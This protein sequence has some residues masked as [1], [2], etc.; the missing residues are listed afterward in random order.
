VLSPALFALHPVQAEA[1]TYASGRSA[2]L[3]GAL[4]LASVAAWLVGRERNEAGLAA[5]LSPALFA[6][7]LATK[8]SVVA[9]PIAL[10]VLLAVD[11]RRPFRAADALRATA[12]HWGVLGAAAVA[13]AASPV[14]R[15]MLAAS[16]ALRPPGE[17]SLTHLDALAWLAA[18][19]VRLDR[20]SADP[21]LAPV[22]RVGPGSVI[23]A[24]ALI[25]AVVLGIAWARRRPAIAFGIL[26]FLAWLPLAGFLLPRAD[27]ANERQL[28]LSLAGPAWLAGLVLAPWAT[29]GGA[30]R[31]AVVL[32]VVALGGATV[33]RNR[34]YRDE[35]AF[36]RDAVSGAPRKARAHANLGF[37]LAAAC[38]LP[39][40]EA[41]LRRAL[42]LDPG[43]VRAAVNLRLLREGVPLRPGLPP[44]PPAPAPSP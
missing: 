21:F 7:A 41:E 27:P 24:A 26:W 20:P 30:R 35:V 32:A 29:A 44:C 33:V 18:Q 28:Y 19:V 34:V 31:A 40:A 4:A 1:V 13:Y 25:A 23:E 14:Y 15:R 9:L 8:E 17:A 6:L 16:T 11:V 39:E 42:E 5:V 37:A 12:P 22:T 36:W 38:R 3:S 10:V 43:L 2:S